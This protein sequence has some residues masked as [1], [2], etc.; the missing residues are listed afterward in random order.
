MA[1]VKKRLKHP[2]KRSKAEIA[3]ALEITG[4][5]EGPADLSQRVREYRY[6]DK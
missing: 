5:G 3:W 2:P 6:G 1:A 4:I